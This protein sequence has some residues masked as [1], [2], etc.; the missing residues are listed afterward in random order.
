MDVRLL[1]TSIIVNILLH[2]ERIWIKITGLHETPPPPLTGVLI[3]EMFPI[4]QP[5]QAAIWTGAASCDPPTY[6]WP[7]RSQLG[8]NQSGVSA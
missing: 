5:W 8:N 2:K 1:L 7:I 4:Q 3:S 6:F